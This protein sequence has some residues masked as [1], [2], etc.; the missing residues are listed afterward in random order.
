MNKVLCYYT[1]CGGTIGDSVDNFCFK[2]YKSFEETWISMPCLWERVSKA[3]LFLFAV[4][5]N[6]IVVGEDMFNGP[7]LQFKN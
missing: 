5:D 2:A 7:I 3:P 4:G 6:H 1:V